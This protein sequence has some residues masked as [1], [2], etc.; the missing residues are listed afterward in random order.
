CT[1]YAFLR[2]VLEALVGGQATLVD[3]AD[4]VAR[5][6]VRLAGAAA[7]GNGRL[8][9][10]ATAHPERLQ[11]AL[12]ALGLGWLADRQTQAARLAVA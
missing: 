10:L 7:V 12:P 11:A 3:V 2:P 1:H 6:C 4:A 9:L 8:T 5:Q